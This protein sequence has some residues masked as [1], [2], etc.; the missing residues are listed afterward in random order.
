[1]S[2]TSTYILCS[3]STMKRTIEQDPCTPSKVA[4]VV[5]KQQ[6]WVVCLRN[7]CRQ[8]TCAQFAPDFLKHCDAANVLLELES[9]EGHVALCS[10]TSR[11]AHWQHMDS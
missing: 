9:S 6:W 3:V 10:V 8:Y 7:R 5:H 4:A 2:M 1:M 11:A